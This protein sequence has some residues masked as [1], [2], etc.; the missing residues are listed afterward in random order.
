MMDSK[1]DSISMHCVK[2]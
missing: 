2:T 1:L